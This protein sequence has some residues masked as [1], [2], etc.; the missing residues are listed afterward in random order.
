MIFR[1]GE[2]LP[3]NVAFSYIDENIEIFSKFKYLSVIFMT[4]GVFN[5]MDKMLAGQAL[6]ATFQLNKYLYKFTPITPKHML[7]LYDKL[8]IPVMNY[9]SELWG[10][11]KATHIERAHLS[12]CKR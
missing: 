7:N 10:F 2:R 4:G 6:K 8:V 3:E 5:E 11:Y 12:F 9:C 1:R